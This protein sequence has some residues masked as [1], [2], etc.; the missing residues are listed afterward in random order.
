M[1]G[2]HRERYVTGNLRIL[3]LDDER[4]VGMI[5]CA[6]AERMGMDAR[7]TT[8]AQQFFDLESQWHPTHIIVD[9][10]MPE[11]DGIDV[12]RC[13]A[14]RHCPSSII[15]VSGAES[16]VIEAAQRASVERGLSVAGILRKP[17][18]RMDL[19]ALLVAEPNTAASCLSP[20]EPA[21]AADTVEI[22]AESLR[23]AMDKGQ[24]DVFYQ[25]K[26][27]CGTGKLAG[28]EAL[29]RWRHPAH[30]FITPDRFIPLAERSGLI[31]EL[32]LRVMATAFAWLKDAHPHDATHL[33]V[34][35]SPHTLSDIGFGTRIFGLAWDHAIDPSRVTLEVTETSAMT[36]PLATLDL[37][38]RLRIKGFHLSIDDFGVGYSSMVQLA[39]LPFSEL[40]IDKSFIL[41]LIGSH[42]SQKIV[43]GVIGL[44][45]SLNLRVT[46]EGVEDEATLEHLALARCDFAQG[47]HIGHPMDR[48]GVREW[49]AA[50][51]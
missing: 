35:L 31:G 22:S 3:V 48:D 15:I 36:N 38:T 5:L 1:D 10:N 40:K 33:S 29:A 17:F 45:H 37:L 50:R 28:F 4:Q 12:M 16:R 23:E 21:V 20:P 9:L 30:G 6:M 24:L 13:L 49:V 32:T 44:G 11:T 8:T 47:F 19:K 27:A 18:S 2:E 26:V 46:A 25:P 34:N 41:N 51:A 39:R 42:E 7:A 14:D 43:S